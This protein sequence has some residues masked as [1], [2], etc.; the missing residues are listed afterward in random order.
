MKKNFYQKTLFK[1]GS[2][3]LQEII[4]KEKIV[5]IDLRNHKG[6]ENKIKPCLITKNLVK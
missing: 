6:L 3:R 2:N 5:L 1:F 4:E